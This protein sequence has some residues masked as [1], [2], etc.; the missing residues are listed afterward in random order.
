M[1]VSVSRRPWAGLALRCAPILLVPVLLAASTFP[2]QFHV[3][4]VYWLLGCSSAVVFALGARWPAAASLVVSALAVPMLA[5]EA[6]GLSG[7]VPYLGALAVAD[8][9]AHSQ[10]GRVIA[11]V[12]LCWT[13]A[14]LAGS[15]LDGPTRA[16]TAADAVTIV[17]AVGLPVL[18]GLYLRGQARLA[19]TYRERAADAELRRVAAETAARSDER[20]AMARELH[21]IVAH[22]MASIVLRIGVAEH[23]VGTADPRV[24]EV[25]DDVHHTAA[26]ALS[27]IRRL[28]AALRDPGSRGVTMIEPDSMWAEIDAAVERARAAGFDV[29]VV[30]DRDLVGLDAIARLTALRVTQEALTNVMKHADVNSPVELVIAR[31]DGGVGLRVSSV[32]SESSEPTAAGMGIIGMTERLTLSGGRF[33]ARVAGGMWV[34]DAWLP[35]TAAAADD[36]RR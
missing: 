7:L 35:H 22:H 36:D 19:D 9:A 11:G 1:L 13:L 15:F 32:P 23:V 10:R 8:V 30:V 17:A 29:T 5:A 31:R 34:V 16:W 3:S 20:N 12:A 6:W 27:D 18:F 25:L 2:G 28:Q 4:P 26:A 14:L 33:D 21:D 24:A